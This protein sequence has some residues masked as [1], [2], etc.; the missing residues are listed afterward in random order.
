MLNEIKKY[1]TL[2]IRFKLIKKKLL[3]FANSIHLVLYFIFIN[4]NLHL[5]F[6]FFKLIA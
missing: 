1:K 2:K 5:F 6:K 3:L 4:K